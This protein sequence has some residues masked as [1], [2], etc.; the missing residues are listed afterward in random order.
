MP[1]LLSQ[2]D[3]P[4]W[5]ELS[6]LDK[7]KVTDDLT[8]IQRVM[9]ITHWVG[10]TFNG[11][12]LIDGEL[13]VD[14][15]AAGVD[16]AVSIARRFVSPQQLFAAV[17]GSELYR[18][19][20]GDLL[21]PGVTTRLTLEMAESIWHIA[22]R[23][24]DQVNGLVLDGVLNSLAW[25][26]P[27]SGAQENPAPNWWAM[28]G[29]L[30]TCKCEHC[31]SITS[32]S[33]YLVDTLNWFK[34]LPQEDRQSSLFDRLVGR[35]PDIPHV[36]LS[37]ESSETK[38]P[39]IDIALEA[40]ERV[41]GGVTIAADAVIN[42]TR[43]AEDLRAWPKENGVEFFAELAAWRQVYDDLSTDQSTLFSRSRLDLAHES[44]REYSRS[45]GIDDAALRAK[46]DLF[47][48]DAEAWFEPV[49]ISPSDRL[50]L[51]T[52]ISCGRQS[53]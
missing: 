20:A 29:S 4:K 11:A 43:S 22:Q 16:S 37:C 14:L 5:N 50:F 23:L 33:A 35:R 21:V 46:F 47:S 17:D 38:V 44:C 3:S 18:D 42:S 31:E 51:T 27:S 40:L 1:E 30:D 13:A 10:R 25:G 49:E 52:S 39:Y 45:I 26:R 15:I 36:G 34:A 41:H 28:F 7:G 53:K 9:A 12:R 19:A 48:T 24:A 6:E 2:R 8:V 32:P